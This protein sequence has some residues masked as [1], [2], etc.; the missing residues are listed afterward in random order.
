[1]TAGTQDGAPAHPRGLGG[2]PPSWHKKRAAD[3]A[4]ATTRT[5]GAAHRV[6]A[7]PDNPWS[8]A[9]ILAVLLDD[10]ADAR[11]YA[12][13]VYADAWLSAEGI[14]EARTQTAKL[15]AAAAT[16]AADRA[17]AAV[18]AFRLMLPPEAPGVL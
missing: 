8:R 2:F 13:I 3:T 9:Q 4:A 16:L 15:A 1:V 11:A 14:A 17:R 6:P 5:G 10:L 12:T 18:D 7:L